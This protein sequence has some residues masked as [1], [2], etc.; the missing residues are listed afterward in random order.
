MQRTYQRQVT[1]CIE[2]GK[3][4]Q[5]IVPV[6]RPS[7]S[8]IVNE[9][10]AMENMDKHVNNTDSSILGQVISYAHPLRT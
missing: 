1:K 9:F 6:K 8:N 10:R 4:C 7:I 5:D 3:L 2:I